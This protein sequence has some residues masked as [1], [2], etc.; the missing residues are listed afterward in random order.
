VFTHVPHCIH[1]PPPPHA[2]GVRARA[3]AFVRAHVRAFACVYSRMHVWCACVGT[4]VREQVFGMRCVF[5]D[6]GHYST[7]TQGD[8]VLS[9]N[10]K[11]AS[12]H[13]KS[14][15]ICCND[16]VQTARYG[17]IPCVCMCVCVR[18]RSRV[19]ICLCLSF[20][21]GFSLSFS[22]YDAL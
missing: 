8:T 4:W 22:L 18:A 15:I 1:V 19:S 11:W 10:D 13:G 3:H 7:P 5:L 12:Y 21:V 2:V 14:T 9:I 17:N 6:Y 20:S 16:A